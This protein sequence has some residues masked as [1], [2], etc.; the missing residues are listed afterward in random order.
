MEARVCR[1][2][3]SNKLLVFSQKF[4]TSLSQAWSQLSRC[5]AQGRL[6][7]SQIPTECWTQV[8]GHPET[9]GQ[10]AGEWTAGWAA[11]STVG[12]EG[13]GGDLLSLLVSMPLG[14]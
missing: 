1:L 4:R 14:R 3:G 5:P 6:V 8:P 2:H 13:G 10:S 11:A 12:V 7:D 9:Q